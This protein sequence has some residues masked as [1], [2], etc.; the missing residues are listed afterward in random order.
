MD[1]FVRNL[2]RN[3]TRKQVDKFFATP[4]AE[5]G[6][7]DYYCE[8]FIG[9]NLANVTVLNVEAAEDFLNLY[10]IPIGAP[11]GA[12]A[13]KGLFWSGQFIYCSR[14]REQV[15]DFSIKSIAFEA[16]EKARKA[17]KSTEVSI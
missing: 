3:A 6:I 14:S 16:S 5:V 9:E 15:S 2:P 4:F 12:R 11:K 13:K 8:K 1:I 10:G 17:A 7:C